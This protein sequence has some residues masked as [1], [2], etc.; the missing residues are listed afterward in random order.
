VSFRDSGLAGGST[1]TYRVSA[2][3]GVNESAR[4]AASAPITV[5][6]Q[7]T[8]IFAD[9][10]AGGF[11]NWT[12]VSGMTLDA[13]IGGASPPSARAQTSASRAWA[14]KTLPATYPSACV[15]AAVNLA[16][17]SDGGSLLRFRTAGDTGIV[18]L[19]L[20]SGRGLSVRSDVS[21]ASAS[22]GVSLPT[23]TWTTLELCGTVGSSGTW[24]VY[25][26]GTQVFGPWTA[27]TGTAP[28]GRVVIGTP[29][30]RTITVNVDDVVVDQS[31]GA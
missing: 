22:T 1:H 4:S 28:I 31:P 16:S 15:S 6:G 2:S 24:T 26:N 11:A 10:F 18:R 27:N 14:A 23:G 30:P 19:Y 21:G 17:T 5:L 3:D 20:T 29:D 8:A 25:R 12:S 9:G 13:S 7:S